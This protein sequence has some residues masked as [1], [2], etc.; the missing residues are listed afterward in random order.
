MI[1]RII[2]SSRY[3]ILIAVL[4]SFIAAASTL[5]YAGI[6]SVLVAVQAFSAG[7]SA[8]GG[9]ILA[10]D[11]IEIVD[12]FLLGT[13][14]YIIS[15]GLYELFIDDTLPLPAWLEVHDF[16][17]LK[18]KLIGVVIVVMGVVFLGQLVSWDGERNLLPLGAAI[19]VMIAALTY[20]Q[21]SKKN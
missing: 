18:S 10:V 9:K 13:A 7:V 1:G 15:L 14:F 5:V 16:D 2:S 17:H 20:F 3:L 6:E 12:L 8:K 19:A 4:G 21:V 11:F